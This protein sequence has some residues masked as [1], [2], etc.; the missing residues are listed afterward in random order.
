M[1]DEYVKKEKDQG[2][3]L[4]AFKPEDEAM[5]SVPFSIFF[6]CTEGASDRRMTARD[7]LRGTRQP[8]RQVRNVDGDSC[9]P[10]SSGYKYTFNFQ[11]TLQMLSEVIMPA[12]SPL[13]CQRGRGRQGWTTSDGWM[14]R[15]HFPFTNKFDL[16]QI[17]VQAY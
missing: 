1:D 10:I 4:I 2:T 15:F 17:N 8:G 6:F 13:R 16:F 12:R 14:I 3:S 9:F 7:H 11:Q 5:R